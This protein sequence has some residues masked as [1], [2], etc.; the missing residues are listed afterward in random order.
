MGKK[1]GERRQALL[2]EDGLAPALIDVLAAVFNRFDEDGDGFWSVAEMQAFA[3]VCNGKPFDADEL[4]QICE[5]FAGGADR[6]SPDGLLEMFHVQTRTRANDTW[7][8]LHALGYDSQLSR[9]AGDE[10]AP[11][12]TRLPHRVGLPPRRSASRPRGLRGAARPRGSRPGRRG[13]P[14]P[15][16]AAPAR[17]PAGEGTDRTVLDR[18]TR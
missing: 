13:G 2:K 9:R 18:D 10:P 16:D 3:T 14:S 5:Y 15:P 11:R 6:L 8:D 7:K 4:Q 1:K 17:T 12:V